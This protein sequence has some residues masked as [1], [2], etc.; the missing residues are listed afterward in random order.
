VLKQIKEKACRDTG[1]II[2]VPIQMQHGLIK[3]GAKRRW[4]FRGI[5]A[6]ARTLGVHRNSLYKVLSFQRPSKSLLSRYRALKAGG[7]KAT[8]GSQQ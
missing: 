5:C 8:K 3:S 1:A 6:D 7:A 2:I 4:R